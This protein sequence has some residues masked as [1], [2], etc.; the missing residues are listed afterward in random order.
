MK[1]LLIAISVLCVSVFS[2]G[3]QK[4]GYIDTDS[5]LVRIPEYVQAQQ[6]LSELADKYKSAVETDLGKVDRLYQTYQSNKTSYSASVK[7]SKEQEIVSE[8]K[9]VKEKRKLYFGEDG[10]M[11]KK[12]KELVGPIQERVQNAIDKVAESGGYMIIIDLAANSGV[13]YYDNRYTLD[14]EVLKLLQ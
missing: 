9:A 13:V 5:I 6:Q 10:V 14:N 4:I 2:A 12:T 1:R 7:A 11:A 3:A 8:E